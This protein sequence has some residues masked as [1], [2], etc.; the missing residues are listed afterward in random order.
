[1][2][3]RRTPTQTGSTGL[4][5]STTQ[6]DLQQVSFESQPTEPQQ[7][8][9]KRIKGPVTATAQEELLISTRLRTPIA[10]TDNSIC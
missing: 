6:T 1:M 3:L 10:S 9:P 8:T 4:K 7:G 2:P 5:R